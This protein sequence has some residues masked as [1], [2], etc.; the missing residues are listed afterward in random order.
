VDTA[1][2]ALRR[3][4]PIVQNTFRDDPAK[5]AAW[6]SAKHLERA[7]KRKR[8][9]GGSGGT[10]PAGYPRRDRCTSPTPGSPDGQPGWGGTVRE[11]S[12][13]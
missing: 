11:G 5:L 12:V 13:N 3:V 2:T 10:P 4:D 9:G 8:G 6:A 7:P 1:F